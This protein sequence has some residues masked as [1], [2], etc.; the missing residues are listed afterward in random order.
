MV[1]HS[2]LRRVTSRI[3]RHVMMEGDD[4]PP[5][6]DLKD[7]LDAC[8][9]QVDYHDMQFRRWGLWTGAT[10]V[11]IAVLAL[12]GAGLHLL[13]ALFPSA[14]KG[15]VPALFLLAVIPA[16]VASSHMTK[17][18]VIA[19]SVQKALGQKV[20]FWTQYRVGAA[21][22]AIAILSRHFRA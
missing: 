9:K 8:A 11:V 4:V 5:G 18:F 2:M 20:R 15:Y 17:T 6:V 16:S 19:N 1:E 13:R 7:W 21:V 10:T 22:F 3:I 12:S 14:D